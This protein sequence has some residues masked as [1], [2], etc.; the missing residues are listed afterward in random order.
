MVRGGP[1]FLYSVRKS[2]ERIYYDAKFFA[3]MLEKL[4]LFYIGHYLP[5]S[6]A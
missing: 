2:Y 6:V 1:S 5:A 3:D 4:N